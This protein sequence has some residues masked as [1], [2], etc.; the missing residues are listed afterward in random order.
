MTQPW[1]WEMLGVILSA[2]A[3]LGGWEQMADGGW[4]HGKNTDWEEYAPNAE[5]AVRRDNGENV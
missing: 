5:I 3:R 2:L 1:E 4:V